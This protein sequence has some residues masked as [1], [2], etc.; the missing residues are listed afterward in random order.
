M[1]TVTLT[2]KIDLA[3]LEILDAHPAT[4]ITRDL[5]ALGRLRGH[6]DPRPFRR[7]LEAAGYV[8][9]RAVPLGNSKFMKR[10]RVTILGKTV[11]D[12]ARKN[13]ARSGD[14]HTCALLA[15]LDAARARADALR[16][17][18]VRD[19][20]AILRA[21]EDVTRASARLYAREDVDHKIAARDCAAEEKLL[22]LLVRMPGTAWTKVR[23]ASRMWSRADSARTRLIARGVCV[24]V[25]KYFTDTQGRTRSY[26]VLQAVDN[27]PSGTLNEKSA[28]QGA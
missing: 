16:R 26:K 13:Y 20:D 11:L 10:W 24:E 17:L 21:M 22:D 27:P 28:L 7:D 12:E 9:S 14:P 8:S 5:D 6:P 4:L 18:A 2:L 3:L 1:R 25:L 19:K 23:T 15:D